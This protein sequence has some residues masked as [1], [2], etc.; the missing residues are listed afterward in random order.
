M[1]LLHAGGATTVLSR[2]NFYDAHYFWNG[3]D[4]SLC[5]ADS[6]SIGFGR[7]TQLKW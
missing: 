3:C 4:E 6:Y 2:K 5:K 7:L 1:T